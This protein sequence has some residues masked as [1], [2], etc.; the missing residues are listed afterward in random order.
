MGRRHHGS[1]LTLRSTGVLNTC[2]TRKEDNILG[3]IWGQNLCCV[4]THTLV[5]PHPNIPFD[6][7]PKKLCSNGRK[8]P[9]NHTEKASQ[10]SICA[11]RNAVMRVCVRGGGG[12]REKFRVRVHSAFCNQ[13]VNTVTMVVQTAYKIMVGEA[14]GQ[15]C[16]RVHA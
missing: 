5:R 12:H 2:R 13:N 11:G 7:M 8:E 3:V 10:T 4:W 1:A 15:H 16:Q 6:L 14:H 9:R